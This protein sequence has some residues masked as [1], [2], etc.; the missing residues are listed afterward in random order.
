MSGIGEKSLEAEMLGK[1]NGKN[2]FGG[3]GERAVLL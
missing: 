1:S 3:G 2:S